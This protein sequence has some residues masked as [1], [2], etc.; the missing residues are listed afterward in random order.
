MNLHSRPG[1]GAEPELTVLVPAWNESELINTTI[2]SA[3]A[4]LD[5]IVAEEAVSSYELL[6]VDDGSSD[7]TSELLTEMQARIEPLRVIR[8]AVNS[9]V[10]AAMR[11]GLRNAR[12][13]LIFYTD[14]DLPVDL[15]QLP[16]VLEF[17]KETG[18]ELVA[19][20]R[21]SRADDSVRRRVYGVVYNRLVRSVLGLRVRDVN[22][23]AK[24]LTADANQKVRAR[25]DSIFIDA[26]LLARARAAELLVVE[27]PFDYHPRAAGKSSTATPRQIWRLFVEM[28]RLVPE[29]RR[30]S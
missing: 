15:G 7:G 24:L 17:R 6:V 4:C 20:Y 5:A 19:G 10:G 27:Y 3:V 11:T 28:R 18:A 13:R 2:E 16:A 29:L 8:H 21:T 12:G 30:G 1:K 25:S 9:G 14:A 23:A 26:E 22:F